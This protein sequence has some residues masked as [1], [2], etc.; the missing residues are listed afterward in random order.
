MNNKFSDYT[1]SKIDDNINFEKVEE[2]KNE[3]PQDYENIENMINQ[4]SNLS[5][6]ELLSE[7]LKMAYEKKKNGTLT[8]GDIANLRNTI[9]PMLTPQQKQNFDNLM[10]VIKW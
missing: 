5:Q 10:N 4:Y 8:E 2:F 3:K 7:F 9:Y 1:N 6:N